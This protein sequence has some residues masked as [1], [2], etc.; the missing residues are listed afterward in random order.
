MDFRG[1][2]GEILYAKS[3]C[4]FKNPRSKKGAYETW[5]NQIKAYIQAQSLDPGRLT[6]AQLES[7]IVFASA[8]SPVK[9]H[10]QLIKKKHNS[11]D[12]KEIDHQLRI[13]VKDTAR[14]LQTAMEHDSAKSRPGDHEVMGSASK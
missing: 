9:S 8:L 11:Y 4:G 7:V 1:R 10:I 12:I 5:R 14:K 3:W 13:L 6:E 2:Y